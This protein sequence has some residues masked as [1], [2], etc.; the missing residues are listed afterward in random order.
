MQLRSFRNRIVLTCLH[1]CECSYIPSEIGLLWL[2]IPALV[3]AMVLHPSLNG[4]WITD[5]AWAFALYL[6]AVAIMPQV[7]EIIWVGARITFLYIAIAC[8]AHS[9]H[10]LMYSHVTHVSHALTSPPLSPTL[11]CPPPRRSR[12]RLL[13]LYMFQKA[14]EKEVEVFTANF[15]FCVA[16]ARM[17][18]FVFWLSSYQ[19]LN[20]KYA[21]HFGA[22]YPGECTQARD[23]LDLLLMPIALFYYYLFF[24]VTALVLV[25]ALVPSCVIHAFSIVRFVVA[26]D[27]CLRRVPGGAVAS[28]KPA[29]DGRLRVLLHEL[30]EVRPAGAAATD[31]LKFDI[32]RLGEYVYACATVILSHP[33][34]YSSLVL[35]SVHAPAARPHT[36]S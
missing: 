1:V 31:H 8:P 7:R 11:L 17:L 26:H 21:Q 15:V 14:R 16:V 9:L 27:A 34:T 12:R 6:E 25:R 19:E 22:K 33:Y 20:D 35:S 30:R 23:T 18:H 5:T 4:N 10:I 32:R 28:R 13:Q 2:V 29:S 3:I 36:R 24:H